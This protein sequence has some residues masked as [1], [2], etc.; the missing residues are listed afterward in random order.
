[1]GWADGTVLVTLLSLVPCTWTQPAACN[2]QH[3]D[4]CLSISQPSFPWS[5]YTYGLHKISMTIDIYLIDVVIAFLETCN[6][7]IRNVYVYACM[8]SHSRHSRAC[9][10]FD[11]R[12]V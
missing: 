3:H 5:R 7:K 10:Y 4:L 6:A 8:I 12:T 2:Y 9:V 11:G 1:V